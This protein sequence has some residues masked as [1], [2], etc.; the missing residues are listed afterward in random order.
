MNTEKTVIIN[1]FEG[2]DEFL[3]IHED[4][5]LF[6]KSQYGV[7]EQISISQPTIKKFFYE[8]SIIENSAET[9]KKINSALDID[10]E[11]V[12][13]SVVEHNSLKKYCDGFVINIGSGYDI[14]N[15]QKLKWDSYCDNYTP[16]FNI[17]DQ[18]ALHRAAELLVEYNNADCSK[19]VLP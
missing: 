17:K 3:A 8:G 9:T 11:N 16:L 2:E 15:S 18:P 4:N 19:G 1:G 12:D 10:S 7:Y 13:E 14:K 6:P 5:F